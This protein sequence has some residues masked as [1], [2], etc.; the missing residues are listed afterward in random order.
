MHLSPHSGRRIKKLIFLSVKIHPSEMNKGL[1][2][3]L[4]YWRIL[5]LK[6]AIDQLIGF[7]K[8]LAELDINHSEHKFRN[9]LLIINF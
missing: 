4:I 6:T 5:F 7:I 3:N 1:N 2:G 9:I 8:S